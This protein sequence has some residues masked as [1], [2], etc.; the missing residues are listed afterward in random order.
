M[1]RPGTGEDSFH[2]LLS[3][4]GFENV[5]INGNNNVWSYPLYFILRGTWTGVYNDLGMDGGIWSPV[6]SS[7]TYAYARGYSNNYSYDTSRSNRSVGQAVHCIV[8]PVTS[9]LVNVTSDDGLD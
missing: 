8:R 3:Q 7:A 5:S 6:A 9:N 1:P 4:Y 2:G